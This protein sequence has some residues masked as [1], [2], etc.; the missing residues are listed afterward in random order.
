M[1]MGE[2]F[3]NQIIEAVDDTYILEL[4]WECT[5]FMVVTTRDL[6]DHLMD[7]YRKVTPTYHK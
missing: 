2:A 1:N 7:R 4:K 5:A 3:K 6:I